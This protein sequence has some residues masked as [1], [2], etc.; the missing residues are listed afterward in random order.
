VYECQQIYCSY[1]IEFRQD[2]TVVQQLQVG[3]TLSQW[4]IYCSNHFYRESSRIVFIPFEPPQLRASQL[5]DSELLCRCRNAGDAV[6]LFVKLGKLFRVADRAGIDKM[7]SDIFVKNQLDVS[8]RVKR[9]YTI[10]LFSTQLSR[11][12]GCA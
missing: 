8:V 7:V 3:F 12:Y 4:C 10:L 1:N 6:A 5:D 11:Y 2:Q 9:T